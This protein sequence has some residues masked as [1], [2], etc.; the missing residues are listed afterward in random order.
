MQVMTNNEKK[1]HEMEEIKEGIQEDMDEEKKRN[2]L[3]RL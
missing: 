1:D 3:I 2:D